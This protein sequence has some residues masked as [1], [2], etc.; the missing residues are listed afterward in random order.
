M[1]QVK[2]LL[3]NNLHAKLGL[4]SLVAAFFLLPG[5]S[6][7]QSTQA[8]PPDCI[9]FIN[10]TLNGGSG[11]TVRVPTTAVSGGPGDNRTEKCQTWT[12]SYQATASSGSLTSVAFQAATGTAAPTAMAFG[13]WGGTVTTGINPNTSSVQATS[14][15]A[16]GCAS[17]SECNVVNS[18][19]QVLVTRNTFVGTINGV[20]YGYRT[21]YP[22]TGGGGGGGGCSSPCPV[23]GTAAAGSVPSGNPVQVA[24][25]DGTDIRTLLTDNTGKLIVNVNSGP[26]SQDVNLVKVAGTNVLNGG[27][28][29][30]QGVG[31]L[32][33]AG[34]ALTGN[35]NLQGISDGDGANVNNV[36]ACTHQAAVTLSSGT[37][38]VVV[39]GASS[40]TTRICHLDFNQDNVANVT[41]RQG[42]GTTC[43][44]NQ[45]ALSGVYQNILGLAADYTNLAPLATSLTNRDICL[46]FSAS[47]TIGGVVVYAQF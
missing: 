1:K 26:T 35:P 15:F 23:V 30:S 19:V 2:H 9:V 8:P 45:V 44:T 36:F 31:G 29:G 21:G 7:A 14:T 12:L 40:K 32:A 13:N 18:W 33:A 43:G 11:T 24:G 46:H 34:A 28:A 5:N 17:M 4:L 38:V 6:W 25:Q 20:L 37:D 41:I 22:G 27:V 42:T 16:T 3:L 39:A 47:V 10:L